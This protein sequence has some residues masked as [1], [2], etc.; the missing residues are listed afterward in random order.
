MTWRCQWRSAKRAAATADALPNYASERRGMI[1]YPEFAAKG[2]QIGSGP[3]ESCGKTLTRRRKGSGMRWDADNAEA[4]MALEAVR[5]SD[6]W[7]AYWRTLVPAA[8]EV[9]P[10]VL[11]DP[12]C[13]WSVRATGLS[14]SSGATH[15]ARGSVADST[16]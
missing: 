9:R 3:T 6:P 5:E 14:D 10:K 4:V 11:P 1:R 16:S 8:S 2:W 15:W 7:P 12:S 13:L